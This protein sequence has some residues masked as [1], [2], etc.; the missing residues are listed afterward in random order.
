MINEIENDNVFI[1]FKAELQELKNEF[2]KELQQEQKSWTK[3]NFKWIKK[4][5]K[6]LIIL[7]KWKN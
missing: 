2:Y 6:E 1:W 4:Y 5:K 7:L 3:K